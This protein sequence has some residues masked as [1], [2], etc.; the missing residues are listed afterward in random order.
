MNSPMIQ[1]QMM[2]QN[3]QFSNLQHQHS[4]PT[5]S[6]SSPVSPYSDSSH[7]SSSQN[8]GMNMFPGQQ[9]QPSQQTPA[10]QGQQQFPQ[11]SRQMMQRQMSGGPG[12]SPVP[13]DWNKQKQGLGMGPNMSIASQSMTSTSQNFMNSTSNMGQNF[14]QQ[15]QFVNSVGQDFKQQV[16][17]DASLTNS[18]SQHVK[19]ELRNKCNTRLQ[20]QQQQQ[21]Q[22]Q[23]GF[24]SDELPMDLLCQ[25]DA[26]TREQQQGHPQ[27]L[28]G[29]MMGSPADPNQGCP[30]EIDRVVQQSRQEAKNRYEKFRAMAAP[31]GGN[32]QDFNQLAMAF[33]DHDYPEVKATN[34]FRRQLLINPGHKDGQ[35]QQQGGQNTGKKTPVK[36]LQKPDLPHVNVVQ[37][38]PR[39]PCEDMKPADHKNSLLQQLLSE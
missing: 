10:Q 12:L 26:L 37:T 8:N 2:T 31:P 33:D 20:N 4:V 17:V 39:T 16:G 9:G 21:Q 13:Q 32:Q 35:Q 30:P 18:T 29:P 7:Y 28:L 6:M 25:I 27:G 3:S 15:M 11:M 38:E 14:D 36:N 23:F 24:V 34:L 5:S 19:R 1:N 22:D